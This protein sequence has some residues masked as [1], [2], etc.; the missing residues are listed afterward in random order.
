MKKKN[1]QKFFLSDLILIPICIVF[2]YPFYYLVI[3][4]F[5]T[6]QE[7]SFNPVAFPTVLFLDNYKDIF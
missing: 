6:M 7:M 4:T 1:E 2:L 5:K 3:N